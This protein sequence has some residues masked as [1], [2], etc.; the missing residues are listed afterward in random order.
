[1]KLIKAFTEM[2]R[3]SKNNYKL[4]SSFYHIFILLFRPSHSRLF[5]SFTMY[6]PDCYLF[7]FILD[8]NVKMQPRK[9]TRVDSKML[10]INNKLEG[11]LQSLCYVIRTCCFSYLVPHLKLLALAEF[12][13]EDRSLSSGYS[14]K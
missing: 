14:V 9:N 10:A 5:F 1:M 4:S 13:R 2:H 8:E 3:G 7:A 12:N 11:Y 6:M